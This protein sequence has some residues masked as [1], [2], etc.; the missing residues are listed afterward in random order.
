MR[1]KGT[2]YKSAYEVHQYMS[3]DDGPLKPKESDPSLTKPGAVHHRI[4]FV[5]IEK[6]LATPEQIEAARTDPTIL[7]IDF[8]NESFEC[9]QQNGISN[10]FSFMSKKLNNRAVV[11]YS[12]QTPCACKSC[13]KGLFLPSSSILAPICDN[14]NIL[15]PYKK[16]TVEIKVK[17]PEA[18]A[19]KVD[20]GVEDAAQPM[21]K[22]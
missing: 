8:N 16:C 2:I 4:F 21:E 5:C 9:T 18:L 19:Q 3:S 6:S 22:G 7:I 14:A 17:K 15:P 10:V 20:K 12:R 11:T 1:D 13:L